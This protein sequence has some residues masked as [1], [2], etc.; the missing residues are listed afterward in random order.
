MND[1]KIQKTFLVIWGNENNGKTETIREVRLQLRKMFSA[2]IETVI[3][4]GDEISILFEINNIKIGIESMGDYLWYGDLKKHL[5][6]FVINDQCD[7]IIC[8]CRI[9]NEV[10]QH[11][12]YLADTY[13]YRIIWA[14]NYRGDKT[15]INQS[16]INKLSAEHLSFLV[17][18]IVSGAI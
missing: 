2:F 9:R 11:I 10:K 1:N 5:D 18:N 15:T 4:D 13:D 8:A 6:D 7:V 3:Y 12:E 14:T 16:L 17:D